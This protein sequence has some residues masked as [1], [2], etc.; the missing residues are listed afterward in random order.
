MDKLEDIERL[1]SE[2]EDSKKDTVS[3][4]NNKHKKEDKVVNKI[5]ESYL[6]PGYQKTVQVGIKKLYPDVVIPE[7]KHDG[8]ACCDIRAYRVVKM[9]NGMGVEIDVPS[10]FESITLYQGYSV[11]IGTGF[12]LNIPEGWC[13]NVE[14]RS[15][16]SFDEGV[17]VTNAPGK[18]E[19]TYKGEYMV[20][21]T[22]INKKPTVIHKNDRIAQMEIVPQYK[23]VLEEVTDI[24]VEDGNERGEKGLG[25][26]GVK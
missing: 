24:E 13:V 5:P 9:V 2:K 4:K 23:M 12:K 17:V 11:R 21:L 25:S 7:Y 8:D 1:L 19:F 26:S 3:E 10:D 18:C 22:K 6:T 15:G 16:F 14:G 20:N